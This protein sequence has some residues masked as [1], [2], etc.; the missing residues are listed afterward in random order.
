MRLA[1]GRGDDATSL[2]QCR[3]LR[4][5]DKAVL[6]QTEAGDEVWIPKS[7]VHDDS[8]IYDGGSETGELVVKAWWAEKEG[9]A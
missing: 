4:E 7:V 2:G 8:E 9:L 6:V 5:T 3:V 1:S